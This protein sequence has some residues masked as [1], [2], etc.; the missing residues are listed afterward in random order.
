MINPHSIGED[1][2]PPVIIHY[3]IFKNAGSSLDLALQ[4]HFGNQWT[5]YEGSHAHD[6]RTSADIGKFLKANPAIRALSSHLARPPLPHG[7]ALP[8]VFLRNP[9]L[10]AR[11]VYEFTRKDPGQPF[12]EATTGTFADYLDW[13]LSGA[14]GGV[15][16]RNYQVIHLSSAS[17]ADQGILAA[18]ASDADLL[19]AKALLQSWKA[20]GIVEKYAQSLEVIEH[21]YRQ[22]FPQLALQPEHVNRSDTTSR[23]DSIRDEIGE[24]LYL[25]FNR[26]NQLDNQL[27]RYAT[28]RLADLCAAY[29]VGQAYEA[30]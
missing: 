21:A 25:E 9:L 6:L 18:Q 14:P 20:I 13:A 1:D 3:H 15:V 26:Q 7:N 10:R 12:R 8:I 11:S 27:Y 28:E 5:T 23:E 4:Q 22:V 30:A 16:I 29:E 17:F 19:E 2:N 24:R